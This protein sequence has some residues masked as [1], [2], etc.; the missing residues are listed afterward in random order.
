LVARKAAIEQTN[1]SADRSFAVSPR[2]PGKAGA[3]RKVIVAGGDAASFHSG[4]AEELW[5]RRSN[6]VNRRRQSRYIVDD[7]IE[8]IGWS[9][10][11]VPAQAQV[12]SQAWIDAEVVIHKERCVPTVGIASHRCV[13]SDCAGNANHEIG[14]RVLGHAVV[15][16]ENAVVVEQ[17][18]LN[19]F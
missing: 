18:L 7:R 14:Q 19:I 1:R 2:I 15:E 16:G 13:L 3:G 8:W 6:C 4:I 9:S 11:H 10:L 17:R 12:E 5:T